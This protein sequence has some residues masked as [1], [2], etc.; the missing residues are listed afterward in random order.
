[1]SDQVSFPARLD[2]LAAINPDAPAVVIAHDDRTRSMLTRR[3]LATWSTALAYEFLR[4]GAGPGRFVVV[5]LPNCIEHYVATYAT[6]RVGACALPLSH[7]LPVAELH[8]LIDLANPAVLVSE[9]PD[10]LS[11]ADVRRFN[12]QHPTPLPDVVSTPGKAIA[13]GGSTGRPKIIVE[14]QPWARVPG[15]LG[16]IVSRVGIRSGQ[17]QLVP[18]PLYH[19]MP[20]GWGHIGIFEE[21]TVVVMEKFDADHALEL[22]EE[23]GVNFIATAPTI[24]GRLAR[25]HA[26]RGRDVSSLEAIFHSASVCPDW[27]KRAWIELIGP[28][29]IVEAYGATDYIGSCV[30]RGDE[31]L[32][33]PGSV[34]RPVDCD[35]RILDPEGKDVS[36]GEVGEVFMRL[37]V[38]EPQ[39]DYVGAE[40]GTTPDGFATVGDLGYVDDDGYLYIADRRVDM[41]V[42]GGANVYPAEVEAALT[43]NPLVAD[44]AVIGL[45]DDEWGRRVH[46]VLQPADPAA[47]PSEAELNT[48]CRQLLAAYKCP[49]TYEF[50]DELPRNAAGKIRRSSLIEERTGAGT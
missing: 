7:R 23:F 44:C 31:W 26:G 34:G 49:K 36:T 41:I 25:A 13:S 30:I 46:A 42:S 37:H 29:R 2:A 20:F 39:F 47:P 9:T 4:R 50:V 40:I 6:W 3:Q 17:V 33:H 19:N 38:D 11:R 24:L 16:G 5:A 27:V 35:L 12:L 48:H 21:H 10:A 1:V 18:G 32:E 28:T 45:P 8:G 43:S 14:P 15:E 22:I